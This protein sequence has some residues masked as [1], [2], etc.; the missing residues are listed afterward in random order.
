MKKQNL[1]LSAALVA[2]F[3]ASTVFA[4]A[5]VTGKF[6]H[7][8]AQLTTGAKSTIKTESTV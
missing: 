8:S 6:V 5:E 2:V 7:E 3:S 1:I 4:E